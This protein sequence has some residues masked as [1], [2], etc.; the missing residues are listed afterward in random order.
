MQVVRFKKGDKAL[1][2]GRHV[3]ILRNIQYREG[4]I[5]WSVHPMHSPILR[6]VWQDDL[7]PWSSAQDTDAG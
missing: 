2:G 4:R 5:V 6:F 1:L 7:A 3:V